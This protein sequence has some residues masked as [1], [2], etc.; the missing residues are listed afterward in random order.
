MN[1]LAE[2]TELTSLLHNAA[3]NIFVWQRF[4]EQLT[5]RLDCDSS[6]L[7]ATD[8][9]QPENTRFLFNANIPKEY[10]EWYETELNSLD[11]F[12]H[13]ISKSPLKV[14][15]SQNL[16]DSHGNKI[17]GKFI[18]A[19]GQNYRFGLSI[20]FNHSHS[21]SLLVNRKKMFNDLEL[22][23]ATRYLKNIIPFL[24]TAIYEEQRLKINSQLFNYTGVHFDGYIVVDRELNILFSNPNHPSFVCQLDCLN[25]SENLLAIQNSAIEQRL[26]SLIENDDQDIST[27]NQCHYCQITLI[28]MS[29]L[30]NLYPWECHKDGFVFMFAHDYKQNAIINRLEDIFRLS[31]CEAV[32]AFNFMNTPS[33]HDIAT[34]TYRSKET[35]RNH[36]KRTMQKMDVHSQ[37]EL[38][39][40][41]IMLAAI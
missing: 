24:E 13:F 16:K 29:S 5:L 21:F 20:P 34:S 31:R 23:Q 18:Q 30:E 39:K 40:K 35:V 32:C 11:A 4:L 27:H 8:L 28:R 25:I 2:T 19:E 10:Q 36:I 15:C 22:H 9:A 38:M 1:L 17:E 37:A 26:E 3:G 6:A 12:N 41:L 14:F 7:L 33:I